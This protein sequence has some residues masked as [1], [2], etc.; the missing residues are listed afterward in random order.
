MKECVRKPAERL[1]KFKC[2]LKLHENSDRGRCG[3][4]R[5]GTQ[6]FGLQRTGP[7]PGLESL[8]RQKQGQRWAEGACEGEG[9]R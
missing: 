6:R 7:L 9:Q 2:V 3:Q 5:A 4:G 8:L 1:L